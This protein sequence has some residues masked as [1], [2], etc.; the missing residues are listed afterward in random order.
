MQARRRR[1]KLNLEKNLLESL[2]LP[3]NQ[4]FEL[5]QNR[6]NEFD[7]SL[8]RLEKGKLFFDTI[9]SLVVEYITQIELTHLPTQRE[10][11]M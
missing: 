4:L 2:E 5:C 3:Q 10:I 6:A 7:Y 1:K 11:K 9:E 8:R